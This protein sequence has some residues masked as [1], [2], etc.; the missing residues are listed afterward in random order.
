VRL[1]TLL[2]GYGYLSAA[3]AVMKMLGVD[4]GPARLPNSNLSTEQTARLRQ[5]L[6]QLGFF[7]WIKPVTSAS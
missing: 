2:A 1:I 4:V 3:K 6:E 7:E 5:D